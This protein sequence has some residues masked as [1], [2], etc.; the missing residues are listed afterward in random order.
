MVQMSYSALTRPESGRLLFYSCSLSGEMPTKSPTGA[1]A[2]G[3]TPFPRVAPADNRRPEPV[4]RPTC[5]LRVARVAV[6]AVASGYARGP[7]R[8]VRVCGGGI[9]S[10]AGNQETHLLRGEDGQEKAT[11]PTQAARLLHGLVRVLLTISTQGAKLLMP[12]M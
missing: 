2:A 7:D 6:D 11:R 9:L 8:R 4:G 1:K 5:P 12:A 3:E 10:A